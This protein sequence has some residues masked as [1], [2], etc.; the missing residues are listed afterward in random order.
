MT[1]LNITWFVLFSLAVHATVLTAWKQPPPGAGTGSQ[2]LQLAVTNNAAAATTASPSDTGLPAAATAAEQPARQIRQQPARP[3]STAV[4]PWTPAPAAGSPAPRQETTTVEAVPAAT[5]SATP[6]ATRPAPDRQET[7]RRLRSGVLELIA[8][9]LKYPA[10]ARRKGW[11]GTVQL[12]LHIDPDGRISR[13]RIDQTSGYPVL[14][15]AAAE[16]LKLARLPHA[17]QWLNGHAVDLVIP[18]EYRLLDS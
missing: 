8:A 3:A 5:A 4:K 15:N 18:V 14:D 13:L 11:Q 16:V 9:Q 17:K 2:V 6:A 12:E 7:D 1:D 10:M